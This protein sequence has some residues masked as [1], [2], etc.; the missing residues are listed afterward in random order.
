MSDYQIDSTCPADWTQL[1]RFRQEKRRPKMNPSG[2]TLFWLDPVPVHLE[3]GM[4]K[5]SSCFV[6]SAGRGG[7][8]GVP[9]RRHSFPRS[10]AVPQPN[11]LT[12]TDN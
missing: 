2:W 9:C 12:E 10:I 4:D 11:H 1:D 6:T 7:I 5:A 3:Y 8:L